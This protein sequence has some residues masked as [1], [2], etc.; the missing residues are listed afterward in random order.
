MPP[1]RSKQAPKA[2]SRGKKTSHRSRKGE[3]RPDAHKPSATAK[4]KRWSETMLDYARFHD[5]REV[6]LPVDG[7]FVGFPALPRRGYYL[8]LRQLREQVNSE[9]KRVLSESITASA[10]WVPDPYDDRIPTQACWGEEDGDEQEGSSSAQNATRPNKRMCRRLAR[11]SGQQ[12]HYNK[13]YSLSQAFVL[14]EDESEEE[15]LPEHMIRKTPPTFLGIPREVRM[16]IYRCLLIARKAIAVHG[17]WKQV[18]R[19][20]DLNLSTGILRVCKVVCDE[21]CVVLYGENLFLYR[22]RDPTYNVR[23]IANLAT[24]DDVLPD[25]ERDSD[26]EYE[27]E[28]KNLGCQKESSIDVAKYAPLFRKIAVEAEHNRYSEDTQESMAAAI[29][30]FATRD[31]GRPGEGSCNIHTLTIRVMPLWE[32]KEDEPDKGRFTFVDFFQ[33]DTPVIRAIKAVNCQ[34]FHID[35][36]TRYMSR[37]SANAPITLSGKGA[38]RLTVNRRHE[39]FYNMM[40]EEGGGGGGGGD[41]LGEKDKAMQRRMVDMAKRSSIV[42][43]SLAWHIE[44]QC[45]QRNFHEE[46]TMDLFVDSP[47]DSSWN[48]VDDEGM[49]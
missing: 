46:T 33:A 19:N 37:P 34:V 14:P 39:R 4:D 38:C 45:S 44:R 9:D 27:E 21:A 7:D 31:E 18:Y 11:L 41:G 28:E 49:P 40:R 17:G 12:R 24:N 15:E 29:Q 43:D 1:R 48:D 20:N 36:L 25:G 30:V 8:R 26:S 16:K 5:G 32:K 6:E 42:M 13:F 2:K 3:R 10:P 47:H 23:N 35:I 22:L